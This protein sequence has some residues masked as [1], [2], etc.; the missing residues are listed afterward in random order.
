MSIR[1]WP[2]HRM[3][4]SGP[5]SKTA[6]DGPP[7]LAALKE[8]QSLA[9]RGLHGEALR[10]LEPWAE[11]RRGQGSSGLQQLRVLC[12]RRLGR[13][14]EAEAVIRAFEAEHPRHPIRMLVIAEEAW[15][16]KDWWM[17]VQEYLAVVVQDP[18]LAVVWSR[19]NHAASR[20]SEQGS[21]RGVEGWDRFQRLI[22]ALREI[23]ERDRAQSFLQQ[24]E[25]WVPAPPPAPGP[26]PAVGPVVTL[27]AISGR[28]SS[29]PAVIASLRAQSCRPARVHLHL[30]REGHLLDE[31]VAEDEPLL[32]QLTADGWVQVHWV[33]NLG[34][35]RKIGPFLQADGYAGNDGDDDLFITVDDDTLYPPRFVEYL[36]RHHDRHGCIV[37][38]RGRRI[39]VLEARDGDPFMPYGEW[40]DGVREP[41]LSNLPTGQSGVL[42]RRRWFPRDL[43]LDA[44]PALAP[45]HDDLWLRWLT[46]REGVPAVILQPNAAAK[47]NELA[48]PMVSPEPLETKQTLWFA[49]NGPSGG[50]DSAAQALQAY[51]QIRGFDFAAVLAEEQERQAD[52]Y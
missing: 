1:H 29:L 11:L 2:F 42:Y 44:A 27:T 38:H 23:P 35:Y 6:D 47:T 46:A 48:F 19:L 10:L 25:S 13:D 5:D 31:G 51:W 50:N 15:A 17:A 52:F 14:D 18:A 43:E 33:P 39:R 40:H 21:V 37:A 24:V 32:Q 12:L 7:Q 30:S 36:L 16:A 41:R 49:Y 4:M 28:L 45:S 26:V 3:V 8:A 20:L 22:V 9:G 34:P